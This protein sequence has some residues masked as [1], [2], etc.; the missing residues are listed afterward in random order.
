[1]R[2]DRDRGGRV[3][4]LSLMEL[5]LLLVF[6]LL[7]LLAASLPS[8]E[9]LEADRSRLAELEKYRTDVEDLMQ[10]LGISLDELRERSSRLID[11]GLVSRE[12]LSLIQLI[13]DLLAKNKQ[14]RERLALVPE[15]RSR[16][17]RLRARLNDLLERNRRLDSQLSEIKGEGGTE[18]GSC[19]F[20]G[21]GSVEYALNIE[22]RDESVLVAPAWPRR[23]SG[24]LDAFAV[25]DA[26]RRAVEL[27]PPAFRIL[28]L[29]I[30]RA[31]IVQRCRLF[32]R[33]LDETTSKDTYKQQKQLVE[34]YFFTNEVEH[35]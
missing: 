8:A 7:S 33:L 11:E 18:P 28:A 12:R 30:Y 20:D 17:D 6:V 26:L 10:E 9:S 4:G 19:W 15:D 35:L 21:S 22:L 31:S 24:D 2:Q 23:R 34:D 5:T 1:M 27:E 3:V 29:P 25:P 16:E 14:M 32:V 13:D